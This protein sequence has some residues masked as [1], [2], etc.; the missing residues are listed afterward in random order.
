MNDYQTLI[1]LAAPASEVYAALTTQSGLRSWWTA[2]CDAGTAV[3]E[4]ITVRFGKT[5]KVMLIESLL[6]DE[7]VRWR[8]IDAHLEAPELSFTREWIDTTISFRL[9]PE[10]P[11]VTRLEMEHNGLTPQIECYELCSQGW[12]QFLGSLKDY[13]ETGTGAPYTDPL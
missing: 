1:V 12:N 5:Y 8:V 11:A 10:S 13:V 4:P 6:P 9:V 2:N 3:G 7:A